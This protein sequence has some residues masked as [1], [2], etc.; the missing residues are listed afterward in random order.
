MFGWDWG[1]QL[2]D[3]GIFR[4]VYIKSV[5]EVEIQEINVLQNHLENSVELTIEINYVDHFECLNDYSIDL[6]LIDPQEQVV[7]EKSSLAT[8]KSIIIRIENPKLWQV[9]GYG[10]SNL[11]KLSLCL[12]KENS[13]VQQFNQRIGLRTVKLEQ[14]DDEYGQ[15][16]TF[17]INGIKVFA[18]G[19]NYI[20][21][22][23]LLG[24]TSYELTRSLLEKAINANH[25]MIRVWGG[26]IYPPDF[27]YDVCDE[28]GILVWQ[29]LMF[30]CSIYP[31]DKSSFKDNII[32][33][34]QS[35]LKRIRLHPSLALIC[36]NNENETAIEQWN[37][38]ELEFSKQSF[39]KQY[40]EVL[41]EVVKNITTEIPYWRSSPASKELFVNSNSD[42][43]G[44]MHYW[45]VW[46]NL[47]PISYYRKYTPRFMSEFGLQSFP[48]LETIN[49][50][51]RT[52]DLNIFSYV[53][54]QHQKNKT[55]NSKI[56]DY[57]GKMFKYPKNFE[58]L[59]S[60]SQLIQA[61]GIRY[62]VEHWRRNYGVCMGILY[63]QLNDCWPVASWSSIDYYG[64]LKALYYHSKKFYDD[65]LVS[66]EEKKNQAKV[67]LTN[68]LLVDVSGELKY[69][70]VDFTGNVLFEESRL[71]TIDK[72]SSKR[73]YDL[74]FDLTQNDFMDKV[75]YVSFKTETKIYENYVSFVPDK[76]LKL[77]KPNFKSA[78]I[79]NDGLFALEISTDTFVKYLEVKVLG[80]D[81]VFSD[82]FF[83][84][85][86]NQKR[87]IT[88]NSKLK[89]NEVLNKL[90]INCLYDTY[91]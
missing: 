80:E 32:K 72:Q 16:F 31:M 50:F 26:G 87:T 37:I 17:I 20:P 46:H 38:S 70:F 84:L 41:P 52:E 63:W 67:Y 66:I 19:A 71:V 51:A 77:Q 29:D 18:K 1:P 86:A 5:P 28:L 30:A 55:A 89:R 64:R 35:N 54:E 23:N 90:K 33:E 43:Y 8:N 73:F 45:G 83:N 44:D 88:F 75:L 34:V 74:K 40:V 11:Y 24:R 36:G 91:Q 69:S 10:E 21:E 4:D 85:L 48:S 82:N 57:I 22:D 58:S 81:I 2:P 56:L 3:G 27:F 62:G 65:L 6:K 14:I 15:S 42:K 25:N 60:V 7:F 79:D 76:Y 53:M 68:D 47:E 61:E 59:L 13:L 12:K 49:T 78:L 39:I 9:Y